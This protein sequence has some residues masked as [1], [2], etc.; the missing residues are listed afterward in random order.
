MP[1]QQSIHRGL[2]WRKPFDFE[3]LTLGPTFD[4]DE[5]LKLEY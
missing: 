2:Y 5:A 1:M 4:H 3:A